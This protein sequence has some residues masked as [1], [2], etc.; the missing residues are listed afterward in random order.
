VWNRP[1]P[2]RWASAKHQQFQRSNT[3]TSIGKINHS[4]GHQNM[5]EFDMKQAP[6]IE[7]EYESNVSQGQGCCGRN[8]QHQTGTSTC[9]HQPCQSAKRKSTRVR[10]NKSIATAAQ[11]PNRINTYH[12]DLLYVGVLLLVLLPEPLPAQNETDQI[13]QNELA[14]DA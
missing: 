5:M 4:A 1:W 2:N 13:D 10:T 11:I 6:Q 3:W 9:H 14:T 7:T 12:R 8:L